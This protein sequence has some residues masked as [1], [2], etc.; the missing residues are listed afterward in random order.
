M[1]SKVRVCFVD[2]D[3]DSLFNTETTYFFGSLEVSSYILSTELTQYY[4][5][6]CTWRWE[7]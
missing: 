5:V 6:S 4:P 7:I 2:L 3:P 1:Q